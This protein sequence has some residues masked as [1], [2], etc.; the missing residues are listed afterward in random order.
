NGDRST[1][2][3]TTRARDWTPASSEHAPAGTSVRNTW[4]GRLDVHR[5]GS[6]L[7]LGDVEDNVDALLLLSSSRLHAQPPTSLHPTYE[8]E[9]MRRRAL[10]DATLPFRGAKIRFKE[11]VAEFETDAGEP[12]QLVLRELQRDRGLRVLVKAFTDGTEVD[13]DALSLRRATLVVNWLTA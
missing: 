9:L 8:R 3:G 1:R 6:N 5:I 11:R 2:P 12:L 10:A 4:L 13:R 7:S